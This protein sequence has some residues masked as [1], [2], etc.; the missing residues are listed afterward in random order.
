[1]RHVD[2]TSSTPD[3][4]RRRLHWRELSTLAGMDERQLH[5]MATRRRFARGEVVFHAGDPAGALHLLDR[6]RVAVRVAS[7]GG[8]VVTI[9]VLSPGDTFGEQSLVDG[10]GERTA[11]VVA[12]ETVETLALAPNSF[13]ALRA[14][15]PAIDQFLVAVLSDRLRSTSAR[16][17][18]ALYLSAEDRVLRCLARLTPLYQVDRTVAIP[19]TQEMLA[20]M[21]GTTRSTAN[22]VL[23]Q[24][25]RDGVVRI[26]RSHMEV[27]DSGLLFRRARLTK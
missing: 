3:T 12:L 8:D 14:E 5:A 27:L 19:L 24:A 18:D 23:R 25:E 10:V 2:A 4:G 20:S 1:M 16:L 6:G 17:L 7:P 22:R 11:T 9:D 21:A 15:H 13:R 26:E